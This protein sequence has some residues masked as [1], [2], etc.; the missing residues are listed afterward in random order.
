MDSFRISP[1]RLL[2]VSVFALVAAGCAGA[3][4][5]G[6]TSSSLIFAVI[7]FVGGVVACT[8]PTGETDDSDSEWS[9]T[10][11]DGGAP[12]PDTTTDTPPDTREG[13]WQRCCK[14]GEI[15]TCF[16]EAEAI[17]NYGQFVECGGNKC[18][19]GPYGCDPDAGDTSD[20]EDPPDVSDA[21]DTTD[22]AEGS[23]QRCCRNN[24]VD[25]CFCPAGAACNYGW[26]TDCGDGYCVGAGQS[27]PDV[28]DVRDDTIPDGY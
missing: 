15:S 13:T 6:L 10:R 8:Q 20:G 3:S 23:W 21:T 5:L 1:L 25:T 7:L 28:G 26:F 19:I 9:A 27:C 12:I 2:V 22:T 16:C 11:D 17:C 4:G 18:A 14:D 24:Q